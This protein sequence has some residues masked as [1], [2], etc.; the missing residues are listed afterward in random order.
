VDPVS[1]VSS[2]SITKSFTKASLGV[3]N[4]LRSSHPGH[5]ALVIKE[6][7][8]MEL[9]NDISVVVIFK[10]CKIKHIKLPQALINVAK[11]ILNMVFEVNHVKCILMHNPD[12]L[13]ISLVRIVLIPH[14]LLPLG[15]EQLVSHFVS[16]FLEPIG[17]T[18]TKFPPLLKMHPSKVIIWKLL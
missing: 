17:V 14:H 4:L 16:S 10:S 3:I 2:F 13:E 5:V 18:K 12:P 6:N 15:S 1:G 11:I 8:A 7:G 9:A